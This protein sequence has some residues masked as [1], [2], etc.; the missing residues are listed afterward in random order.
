MH[1]LGF[2]HHQHPS[3]L[4]CLFKS[5][6][7]LPRCPHSLDSVILS[8]RFHCRLHLNAVKAVLNNRCKPSFSYSL[9][10]HL[11]LAA[12]EKHIKWAS[13]NRSKVFTDSA[14]QFN[15]R[16]SRGTIY[17]KGWLTIGIL[18]DIYRI[19][20]NSFLACYSIKIQ[21]QYKSPICRWT[22]NIKKAM[23]SLITFYF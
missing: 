15:Q 9:L 3:L 2:R 12:C 18:E 11:C 19:K 17:G 22:W 16:K 6:K 5:I 7:M 10:R 8:E 4:T 21:Q 1:N 14:W 20:S 23:E 13:G